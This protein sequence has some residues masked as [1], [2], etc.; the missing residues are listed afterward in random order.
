MVR[1][2]LNAAANVAQQV[3]ETLSEPSAWGIPE[4]Q[5]IEERQ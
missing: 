4:T 2:G 1:D 3:G 5:E